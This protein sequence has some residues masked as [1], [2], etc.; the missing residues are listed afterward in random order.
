M[1]SNNNKLKDKIFQSPY[2]WSFTTYFAEGFPYTII[3]TI[4]S[5]FFR[6]M[7][8]KL[9]SIGLTSLFGL[10][11]VL[12]FLWGPYIDKFSTKRTWMLIMQ[13]IIVAIMLLSAVFAPLTRGIQSIAI[14]FFIGSFFSATHDI[15]IDGYYMEAL[16]SDG[17]AKFIGYRVMAYRIAMITGAGIISTIGA[18]TNWFTAF[19]CSAL[20]FGLFLVY[21][22]FFLPKV[23]K[24]NPSILLLLKSFLKL[25]TLF[26]AVAFA[27]VIV[28]IR[29]FY[30]SAFYKNLIDHMPFLKKVNF[31][32]WVSIHLFLALIIIIL[33]R[34]KIQGLIARNP[35]SFYSKSFLVFIDRKKIGVILSSII[36]LRTGEFML[37][38]MIAPFFVD[39]GIK[40]HYGWISSAIGIPFSIAGALIG[41]WMI[42][43]FSLKRVVWPFLFLQNFTNVVYMLLALS[44]SSYITVNTGTAEA[45]PIGLFNLAFVCSVHGFDQFAGGLGTAVL[46][47]LL[48]R[49]CMKEFKAA[50]FAI[51]TGLMNISGVFVGV[52]GGFLCSWLGYGYFFGI[53][54]LLSI[55]GM[56]AVLYLP[57][58]IFT[59][60]LH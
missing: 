22:F 54:F 6:D 26:Y 30:Q 40:I 43:K 36:L 58:D 14:L 20:I 44:L 52:A 21:H 59:K 53:S 60:K 42:S 49:F 51:G 5:F 50:H 17:Q 32:H 16:D 47:T 25:K 1:T 48:M 41:G 24:Q 18:T 3:R 10:P 4:S 33:F 29:V 13:S 11:W 19:L 31:S 35:D 55:P 8:V 23:E 28:G 57:D 2:A 45:Q 15:A 46:T 9:E 56:I 34:K 37:S 38:S 39:L 12:K 27:F 7:G